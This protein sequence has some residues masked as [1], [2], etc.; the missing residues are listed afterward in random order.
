MEH[1]PLKREQKRPRQ[2]WSYYWGGKQ[3]V[4]LACEELYASLPHSVEI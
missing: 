1:S 3:A 4:G 2:K